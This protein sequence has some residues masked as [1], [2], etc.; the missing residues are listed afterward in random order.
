MA[1]ESS[2]GVGVERYSEVGRGNGAAVIHPAYVAGLIDSD[3]Y[4]SLTRHHRKRTNGTTRLVIRPTF[5]LIWVLSDM[6]HLAAIKGWAAEQGILLALFT[7]K[8]STLNPTA[9]YAQLSSVSNIHVPQLCRVVVPYLL[10]KH[11]QAERI[12][13]YADSRTSHQ[14]APYTARELEL[15]A[16]CRRT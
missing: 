11:A 1:S 2:T 10:V 8:G 14:R 7:R 3:G 13:E 4:I 5:S 15:T 12:I 9:V 6:P 16:S